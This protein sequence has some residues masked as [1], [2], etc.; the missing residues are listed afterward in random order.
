[1]LPRTR[2]NGDSETQPRRVGA[3]RRKTRDRRANQRN[4][5]AR[6]QGGDGMRIAILLWRPSPALPNE[7]STPAPHD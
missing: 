6:A 4:H 2:L 1:M 5:E 3:D 7:A